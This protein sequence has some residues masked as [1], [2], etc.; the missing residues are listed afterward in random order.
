M[1]EPARTIGFIGLGSIGAPMAERIVQAGHRVHVYDIRPEAM[2]PFRGRAEFAA[3]PRTMAD[4]VDTVLGCLA[5]SDSFREAV[6][7]P[8]GIVAGRRNR[9][10]LHLG[11]NGA[12][13]VQELAAGLQK[14]GTATL[15]APMTGGRQRAQLG[16]LTV[17]ASGPQALF[18]AAEPL[19]SCYAS[20]VVYLGPS[21]GAAQVMKSVNN[22]LSLTNLVAACEALVVGAKAGLDPETMLDVINHGSGQNTA[23]SNKVPRN[24][25]PR[26]FDFG[27]SLAVVMKDIG[28]FIDHAAASGIPTPVCDLVRQIYRTAIQDGSAAD[29]ITTV[30][31]PME[32]LA[33]VTVQ[34]RA[35]VAAAA[36]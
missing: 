11:T 21:V 15:D 12:A 10:Y 14:A 33:G 20:K 13:V 4:Q 7:G 2:A 35:T 24:I 29:D 1:S 22:M 23:T 8:D 18:S 19:L 26:S 36:Q 28:V 16:T 32:K 6:L 30:I 17:M 27:G 31:R 34:S 9:Q 3:S 25:L 5:S